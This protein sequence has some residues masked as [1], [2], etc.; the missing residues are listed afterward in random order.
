[1]G[2][3]NQHPY[4]AEKEQQDNGIYN[5]PTPIDPLFNPAGINLAETAPFQE[6]DKHR[7]AHLVF[8]ASRAVYHKPESEL[9]TPRYAE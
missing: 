1:M 2:A 6:A 4:E 9:L 8:P 7:I 3:F 5:R